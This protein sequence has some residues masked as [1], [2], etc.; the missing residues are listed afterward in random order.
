M[1]IPH[2][3]VVLEWSGTLFG[4]VFGVVGTEALLG[5]VARAP[6]PLCKSPTLVA[7]TPQSP[8]DGSEA[9]SGCRSPLDSSPPPPFLRPA[10]EPPV[11]PE[12]GRQGGGTAGVGIAR[13]VGRGR[14]R[15]C[16][17]LH[18]W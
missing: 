2:F 7:L 10:Q 1:R 8:S 15:G 13:Q 9:P 14:P 3:G 12:G 17:F 11:A 4:V 5:V 16:V 18:G 6:S